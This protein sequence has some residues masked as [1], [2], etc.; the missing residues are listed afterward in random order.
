MDDQS[1]ELFETVA[2]FW[3][4]NLEQSR[5]KFTV[6]DICGE[7]Q[8][9]HIDHINL[10]DLADYNLDFLDLDCQS[11]AK[12]K[13]R[14]VVPTISVV[15]YFNAVGGICFPHAPDELGT[16]AAERGRIAAFAAPRGP[17]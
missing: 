15:V 17:T 7:G 9:P 14:R 6:S 3:G 16:I 8:S 5:D 13:P 1:R 4:L 11:S 10:E 2:G 12:Q